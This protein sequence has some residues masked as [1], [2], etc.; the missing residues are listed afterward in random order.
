MVCDI[1]GKEYWQHQWHYYTDE[2]PGDDA[3]T[4]KLIETCDGKKYKL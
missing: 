3:F 2:P 4:L 1:C